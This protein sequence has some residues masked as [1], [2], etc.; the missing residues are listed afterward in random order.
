MHSQRLLSLLSTLGIFTLAALGC[1]HAN[2]QSNELGLLAGATLTPGVATSTTELSFKPSLALSIEYDHRI[3]ETGV[4]TFLVG[5]DFTASP[6]DVITQAGPPTAINQYAYIFLTPEL[7]YKAPAV[8]PV[9]PWFS[10]GGGLADFREGKLRNGQVN[11]ASGSRSGTAEFSGGIDSTRTIKFLVPI[12]FR[13][14]VRDDLSAQPRYRVP[15]T[16]STQNNVI[17]SAGFF[18]KF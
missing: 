5:V 4:G 1:A 13:A 11:T 18:L 12:G 17:L 15:T 8:G 6:F 10:V 7:R 14:E 9:R 2:A 16:G 3:R